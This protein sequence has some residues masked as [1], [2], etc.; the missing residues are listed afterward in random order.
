ME[1]KNRE[2]YMKRDDGSFREMNEQIL[3]IQNQQL[4]QKY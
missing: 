1:D 4:K 3:A 2:E